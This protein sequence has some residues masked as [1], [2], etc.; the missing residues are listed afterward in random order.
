MELNLSRQEAVALLQAKDLLQAL[1][2]AKVTPR[3]TRDLRAQARAAL[4][5]YPENRRL[6]ACAQ[7]AELA[8][9]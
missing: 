9:E 2:N 8:G 7:R 4:R 1:T 6:I 5:W 3:I